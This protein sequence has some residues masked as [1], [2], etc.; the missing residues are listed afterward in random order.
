MTES[1]KGKHF[2]LE[3]DIKGP[4]LKLDHTGKAILTVRVFFYFTFL[5]KQ[6]SYLIYVGTL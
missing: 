4:S 6:E 2:F 3:T 5:I 1:V